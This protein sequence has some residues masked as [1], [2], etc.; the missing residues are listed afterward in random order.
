MNVTTLFHTIPYVLI[1]KDGEGR[2]VKVNKSGLELFQLNEDDYKGKCS[3]EIA[4]ISKSFTNEML[5]TCEESDKRAWNEGKT[6]QFEIAICD[7]DHK[8]HV[9]QIKKIPMYGT[10]KS[11]KGLLIIGREI[12]KQKQAERDLLLADKAYQ[13][14]RDGIVITNERGK[15]LSIN[16]AFTKVT[17]YVPEEVIG[18]KPNILSSGIHERDFYIKMWQ[19]IRSEESWQGEIWNR[20][21][22]GEIYCQ[23]LTINIIKDNKGK[24][25]N[26]IGVFVDIT[27]EEELKKDVILT[28]EIQKNLLPSELTEDQF[29]IKTIYRP[30]R[31]VSGDFYDYLFNRHEQKL[32]G[33]VMD[34]MGHGLSTAIQSSAVRVLFHQMTAMNVPLNK[35][36]EWLNKESLKYFSDDS[37]V[38]AIF[39]EIDFK[40]MSLTYTAAG[41]NYFGSKTNNGGQVHKVKGT[42]LGILSEVSFEQQT[43]PINKGDYFL[44]LS[45][46]LLDILPKD[47]L[48]KRPTMKESI[49]G[50]Y[51]LTH[52]E[53]C[54]DDCS[55]V[56]IE[57]K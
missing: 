52:L 51:E 42:F 56:C 20:R 11:R 33:F 10:G 13:N 15:I 17:G 27:E 29:E 55:A 38:A 14:V 6:I 30:K 40:S 50:L 46:G 37:F 49:K 39:F 28:G 53:S 36:I 48:V 41:I 21:K 57:I 35:Q 31:Y 54:H 5:L 9:Y 22:N 8:E 26:F 43:V 47:F 19:A 44:F 12:T 16:E 45:D 2:W 1:H 18:E 23:H 32:T 4:S 3:L 7:S 34:F 24:I 25:M